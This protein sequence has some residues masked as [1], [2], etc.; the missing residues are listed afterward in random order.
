MQHPF[1][2][3]VT[4]YQGLERSL[5]E[6]RLGRYLGAA[7]GDKHYALRL[8]VWNAQLCEAFYLPMQIAEVCARNAIHRVLIEHHK[9]DWF[10]RGGFLCT[11]PKRLRDELD[12][13]IKDAREKHGAGMTTNY[14]VAGLSF[15]FWVHLLTKNYD[16]VFW[17]TYY[18]SSFPNLPRGTTRE[19]LYERLDRLRLFRNRIA[20]H[21]PIFDHRPRGE[22]LSILELIGWSCAETEWFA[23]AVA[24]ID[25]AI[26]AKP[27]PLV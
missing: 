8:Y 20:H 9:S 18:P 3:T 24:K 6:P 1:S 13:A 23:R 4:T 25:Q 16:G 26:T 21:K 5:S 12:S 11:L 22:Y 27:R 10:N 2:C 19:I 17:P 14:V 7:N 15:G